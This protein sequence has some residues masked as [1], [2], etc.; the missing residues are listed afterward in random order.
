M[1]VIMA[2]AV[3]VL[4]LLVIDVSRGDRSGRRR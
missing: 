4:A 1:E 2:V 3:I